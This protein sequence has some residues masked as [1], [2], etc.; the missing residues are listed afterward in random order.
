MTKKKL[1]TLPLEVYKREFFLNLYLALLASNKGFQVIIGEQNDKIFKIA[2]NGIFL[3]KDHANWSEDIFK[4]AKKRNMKTAALDAEGLI[5]ESDEVYI[6]NR[7]SKWILENIDV[8]FLWGKTQ[9]KLLSQVTKGT[10]N[11]C[12]TGSPKFDL[13]NLY[14]KLNK[15]DNKRKA[16]KVLIN[17]RFASTN[18]Q[19][20]QAEK[21]NLIVLVVLKNQKDFDKY[22]LFIKSEELIYSEFEKLIKLLN[23][24]GGFQITIRPH[25]VE[26]FEFY[27]E[28]AMSLKNVTVDNTTL[29]YNQFLENDC[30]IHDGCT[31]AVEAACLGKPVFG[32]RPDDLEHAYSDYANNYSFNYKDAQSLY[33]CLMNKDI[34][35][36]PKPNNKIVPKESIFNWKGTNKNATYKILDVFN[37]LDLKKQSI[38]VANAIDLFDYKSILFRYIK[39]NKII[40]FLFSCLKV[41]IFEKFVVGR[42]RLDLKYPDLKINEIIDMIIRLNTLDK[43]TVLLKDIKINKLSSKTVLLYKNQDIK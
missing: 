35:D 13:C 1:L 18:I 23:N 6:N 20:H 7:A 33:K 40:K 31:T 42:Q 43:S 19:H 3:H 16:T 36:Y 10:N 30:I 15:I 39:N 17:T 22:A 28:L 29:I 21:D 12:F 5:Y 4:R 26:D 38:F 34:S 27:K 41:P 14:A 37:S 25:P 32:L 11:Y 24:H 2:Q 8:I 9:R